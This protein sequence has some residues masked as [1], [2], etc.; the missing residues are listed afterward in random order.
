MNSCTSK[1]V[2]SAQMRVPIASPRVAAGPRAH[3][4]VEHVVLLEE[5]E[6]VGRPRRDQEPDGNGHHPRQG[7]PIPVDP[8]SRRCR[9]H[10]YAVRPSMVG[11]CHSRPWCRHH[12]RM[13][14]AS[15]SRRRPRARE[16]NP[17]FVA[18]AVAQSFRHRSSRSGPVVLDTVD[19][20]SA[21][22]RT[23][24]RDA[25]TFSVCPHRSQ[26][27]VV[28]GSRPSSRCFAPQAGHSSAFAIRRP[29]TL[30]LQ[31]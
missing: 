5:A 2:T 12:E 7:A 10:V 24:A 30:V 6:L 20:G 19:L 4:D 23:A 14:R 25:G 17:T 18:A 13:R 3:E 1:A 15:R 16:P 26:R 27:N 8:P 9:C 29:R 21:S 28:D 11:R 22:A 31:P